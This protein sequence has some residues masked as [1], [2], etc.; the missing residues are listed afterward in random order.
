[1]DARIIVKPVNEPACVPADQVVAVVTAP[2]V[3]L[4]DIEALL[5]CFTSDCA[6]QTPPSRPV[7]MEMEIMMQCLLS[8]APAPMQALPPRTTV[9]EMET[10]L[11]RLLPG[12]PTLAPRV[13][14]F[15]AH[16]AWSTI[17]CF[18]CGNSG[19]G[20]GRCPQL[21]ETFP[22]ML[23]GWS[24]EKV[25][26]NYMMISPRVAAERLWTGNGD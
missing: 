2:S 19:H 23:P 26:A 17:V 11:Q 6:G 5:R 8:N 3:G 1:M 14:P 18:S 15:P 7:P 20:V 16:R 22:Y 4:D 25:S 13:R 10:L 12:V 21:D 24:A 9:T